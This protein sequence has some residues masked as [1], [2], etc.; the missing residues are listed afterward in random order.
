MDKHIAVI[1]DKNSVLL[2]KAI[3]CDTFSP[4]KERLPAIFSQIVEN[5]KVVYI[6]SSFAQVVEGSIQEC[7]KKT[8]P[9][10]T[11]IKENNEDMYASAVLER[12]IKKALGSNI[13]LNGE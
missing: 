2:F 9:I 3:G 11:V 13:V 4:K 8:Y 6:F 7:A 12:Q 1:G 10:V 5:Y